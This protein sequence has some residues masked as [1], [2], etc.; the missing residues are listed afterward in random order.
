MPREYKYLFIG[1][2]PFTCKCYRKMNGEM[3]YCCKRHNPS[4]DITNFIGYDQ[5]LPLI[6]K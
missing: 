4:C 2:Q 6:N 3:Y 5:A 1:Y